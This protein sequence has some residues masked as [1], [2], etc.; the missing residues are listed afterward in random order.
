MGPAEVEIVRLDRARRSA[1]E[2]AAAY[3][4]ALTAASRRGLREGR[5]HEGLRSSREELQRRQSELVRGLD[6]IAGLEFPTPCE[7]APLAF[8]F[9][10]AGATLAALEGLQG[11]R[12]DRR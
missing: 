5:A 4:R 12:S 9:A 2:A 10:A 7:A 11:A 1:E 8:A 3:V 6:R